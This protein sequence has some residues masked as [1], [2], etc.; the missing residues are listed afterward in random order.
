MKLFSNRE[1]LVSLVQRRQIHSIPKQRQ[2]RTVEHGL[3]N[4]MG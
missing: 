3:R 4:I 1:A 2:E